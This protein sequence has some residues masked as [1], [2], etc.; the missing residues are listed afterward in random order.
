MQS[1][2][3]CPIMHCS[4]AIK[5][6]SSF[7]SHLKKLHG[8][9]PDNFRIEDYSEPMRTYRSVSMSMKYETPSPTLSSSPPQTSLSPCG[10]PI[11]PSQLSQVKMSPSESPPIV[12]DGHINRLGELMR[13]SDASLSLVDEYRTRQ[14]RQ[15]A[16]P[17]TISPLSLSPCQTPPLYISGYT[18]HST[19]HILSAA[20]SPHTEGMGTPDYLNAG[21]VAAERYQEFNSRLPCH[22][23]EPVMGATSFPTGHTLA[24]SPVMLSQHTAPTNVHP[25]EPT[26][27][28]DPHTH[29]PSLWP[30]TPAGSSELE[31]P[32][33]DVTAGSLLFAQVDPSEPLFQRHHQHHALYDLGAAGGMMLN[34]FH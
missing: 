34:G 4:A 27:M 18:H 6:G 20:S 10:H 26:Y 30:S 28:V 25:F 1:R 14:V 8:L 32:F 23:Q 31:S 9:N 11:L 29:S 24:L 2:Y 16:S 12:Y 21:Y 7:K 5:R 33:E 17:G 22:Y 3:R 19:P 13:T 15:T